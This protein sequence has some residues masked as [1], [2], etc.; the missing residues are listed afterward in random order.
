MSFKH[1][2]RYIA[3]FE[4]RSNIRTFGTFVQILV[5]MHNM[6]DSH[7]PYKILTKEPKRTQRHTESQAA[8]L[9]LAYKP[10]K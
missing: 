7:L 4:G 8:Q 2:H 1:L 3:E 5:V 6:V 10:K 9:L